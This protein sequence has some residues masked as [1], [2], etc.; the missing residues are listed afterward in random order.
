M[1]PW[2]LHLRAEAAEGEIAQDVGAAAVAAKSD[3]DVRMTSET[4]FIA[5]YPLP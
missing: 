2:K 5:A 4:Y 1:L 3:Y